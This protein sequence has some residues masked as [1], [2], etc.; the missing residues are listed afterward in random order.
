[1]FSVAKQR[2][3]ETMR[4]HRARLESAAAVATGKMTAGDAV[5]V[6]LEKIR[7]SASLKPRS[8]HY[9]G[10]IMDFIDRSWPALSERTC[11]K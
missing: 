9:R 3:P 4:E 8:K 7:V 11:A 6:Y 10:M 2:L 5:R 1:M